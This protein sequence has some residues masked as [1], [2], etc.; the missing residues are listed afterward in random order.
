MA[1][2]V[3]NAKPDVT[4]VLDLHP[5]VRA[6]T[7]I[8]QL[9]ITRTAGFDYENFPESLASDLD[10]ADAALQASEGYIFGMMPPALQG[11]PDVILTAAQ[12]FQINTEE[13]TTV[14]ELSEVINGIVLNA[15]EDIDDIRESLLSSD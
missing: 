1:A 3:C 14:Q 12:A 10:I 6:H 8:A 9:M 15:W 2:Y 7:G 13:G 4:T 5:A 11:D